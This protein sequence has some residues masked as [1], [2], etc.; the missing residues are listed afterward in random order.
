MSSGACVSAFPDWDTLYAPFEHFP[1]DA[2]REPSA[3]GS[4]IPKVLHCDPKG[5][6]ALLQILFSEVRGIR[7]SGAHSTPEEDLS[8]PIRCVDEPFSSIS[9][10]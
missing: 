1:S 9:S 7:L 10:L 5:S 6:R 2:R 4:W 3:L 8:T